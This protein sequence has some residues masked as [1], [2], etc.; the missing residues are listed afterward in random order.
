MRLF[1]Q[2]PIGTCC[3]A[4]GQFNIFFIIQARLCSS[5][6]IIVRHITNDVNLFLIE[7]FYRCYYGLN[8]KKNRSSSYG[9]EFWL[10]D[11]K[12]YTKLSAMKHK[13]LGS[14]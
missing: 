8:V 5:C 10:F 4:L 14:S 2:N 1:I 13:Y 12:N 7:N 6:Q 3:N 11:T 9:S